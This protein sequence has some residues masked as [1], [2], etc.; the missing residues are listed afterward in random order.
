MNANGS[1][2]KTSTLLTLPKGGY[3]NV[4]L[5]AENVRSSQLEVQLQQRQIASRV[6]TAYCSAAGA[7]RVAQWL[8]AEVTSFDRVVQF[9]RDRV[10]EGAEPEVDLLRI[11][12]ERDR[13]ASLAR[14]ALEETDRTR[15]A[16]VPRNGNARASTGRV[17]R[18]AR[19]SPPCRSAGSQRGPGTTIEMALAREA[20]EQA[21]ANLRLRQANAKADPDLHLGY[22]RISGFDTVYL[23]AQIPVPVRN[24][25]QG[26]SKNAP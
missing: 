2:G 10:R 4:E 6:R 12:V 20:V 5:A 13:L 26:V 25:N 7:A 21:R 8:E 1:E 22:E 3:E 24:R 15:I 19:T 14:S 17:Y 23:A 16:L 9:H 18:G 11:E